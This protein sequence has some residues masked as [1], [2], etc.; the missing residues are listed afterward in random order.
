MFNMKFSLSIS[1]VLNHHNSHP[2]LDIHV[3]GEK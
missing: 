2:Q 1:L 3:G